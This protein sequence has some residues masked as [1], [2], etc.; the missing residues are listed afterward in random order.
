MIR[1]GDA[2]QGRNVDEISLPLGIASKVDRSNR[3]WRDFAATLVLRQEI[4]AQTTKDAE[5]AYI[6]S[7]AVDHLVWRYLMC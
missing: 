3:T 7:H 4:P 1:G 5:A 2:A 6:R